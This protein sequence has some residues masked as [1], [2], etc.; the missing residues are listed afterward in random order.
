MWHDFA[1]TDFSWVPLLATGAAGVIGAAVT[2]SV[3]SS[4]SARLRMAV[5]VVDGIPEDQQLAWRL[6]ISDDAEVI[7][8]QAIAPRTPMAVS[9]VGSVV[10]LVAPYVPATNVVLGVGLCVALVG[11][12]MSIWMLLS[13]RSRVRAQAR[14]LKVLADHDEQ[15]RAI[16]AEAAQHKAKLAALFREARLS[17]ENV[18]RILEAIECGDDIS[19]DIELVVRRLRRQRAFKKAARWPLTKALGPRTTAVT[20]VDAPPTHS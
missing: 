10:I 9:V 16:R 7:M 14:R 17:R 2:Y 13:A 4:R 18:D 3:S 12:V 11:L 5:E 20:K 8:R 19:A 1:M 6:M 15:R